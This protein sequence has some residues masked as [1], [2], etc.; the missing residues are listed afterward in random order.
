[1][2]KVHV[3]SLYLTN[4]DVPNMK[5]IQQSGLQLLR[6]DHMLPPEY[7]SIMQGQFLFLPMKREQ[8]FWH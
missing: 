6:N 5:L 7:A 1:M 3:S 8:L 4:T 2:C